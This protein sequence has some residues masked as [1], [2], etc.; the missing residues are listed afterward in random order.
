M[1]T[2][3]NTKFRV[4]GWPG[5]D[6]DKVYRAIGWLGKD[7]I[8]TGDVPTG[9]VPALVKLA[10]SHS[11]LRTRGYHHCCYCDLDTV[12]IPSE[13]GREFR[14]GSAEIWISGERGTVYR[15]PDLIIHYIR[16]HQYRPPQEYIDAVM[17]V[18]VDE[19]VE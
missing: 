14:L 2:K 5:F 16:D 6:P 4:N 9:L 12:A 17:A 10:R 13:G 19:Q 7:P 1:Y 3:D 18:E 15:A 11:R 8:P